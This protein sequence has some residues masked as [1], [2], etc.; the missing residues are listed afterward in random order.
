MILGLNERRNGAPISC[1]FCRHLCET[2]S[3]GQA[4]CV[5]GTGVWPEEG[6]CWGQGR[7]VGTAATGKRGLQ[8][9]TRQLCQTEQQIGSCFITLDGLG[10]LSCNFSSFSEKLRY[11]G[12]T[13]L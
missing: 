2:K 3:A 5:S 12:E 13:M 9:L 7:W 8:Q 10:F 1:S 6:G 4:R 11:L